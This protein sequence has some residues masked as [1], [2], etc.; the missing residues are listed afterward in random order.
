[1]SRAEG[2][3][4]PGSDPWVAAIH[5]SEEDRRPVGSGFLI[6]G[7]RVLTCAHVVFVDQQQRPELWVALPKAHGLGYRRVRVREVIAPPAAGMDVE[8]V[9]IL[10]LAQPVAEGY[11]AR[12]RQPETGSL[13][14]HRWWAFGFP[15][16]M[17]GNSAHGVVGEE[18]GY[19][20]VRLDTD[21][22]T[23]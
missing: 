17:L 15:D 6:D 22:G 23:E 11:A 1:M 14:G 8:D 4:R 9:A 2:S 7:R 10:V 5:L 19:G 18:L 3:P 12:L 13:V 20:W 21:R 16:G